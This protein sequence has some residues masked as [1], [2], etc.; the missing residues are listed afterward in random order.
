MTSPLFKTREFVAMEA[1]YA[2][3]LGSMLQKV[4]P[5]IQAGVHEFV[6]FFN[7]T[8]SGVQSLN[9]HQVTFLSAL[10]GHS[11][12]NL[13]SVSLAVPEGLA[14]SYVDYLDALAPAVDMAMQIPA[15]L[16]EYSSYVA[17]LISTNSAMLESTSLELKY[18][19]DE[20]ARQRL[21]DQIAAC[22]KQGDMTALLPLSKV[23]RRSADWTEVVARADKLAL[24]LNNVDRNALNKQIQETT[25]LLDLL[26][27]RVVS[28]E[29]KEASP[30]V[31]LHLSNGAYQIGKSLEFFSVV[32]YRVKVLNVVLT[33]NMQKLSTIID[34]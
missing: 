17:S 5:T 32:Y 8:E 30:E 19:R 29:M 16:T 4:F 1:H 18:A 20:Q 28:G 7:T 24:I 33:S 9:Q 25:G 23:I 15:L 27:K 2:A 22:F 14:V 3:D 26:A 11:Y 34:A 21:L 6:N 10:K 12:G 13:M 31:L